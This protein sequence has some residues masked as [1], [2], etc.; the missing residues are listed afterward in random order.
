MEQLLCRLG[1]GL[2][3]DQGPI[4][5]GYR[6]GP[7]LDYHSSARMIRLDVGRLKVR[8]V[9]GDNAAQQAEAKKRGGEDG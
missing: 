9:F 6:C 4:T 3:F 5:L 2:S 1:K 7:R 8:G